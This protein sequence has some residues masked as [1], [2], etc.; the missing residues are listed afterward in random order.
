MICFYSDNRSKEMMRALVMSFRT[1][2]LAS[3]YL[4]PKI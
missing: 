4:Y 2:R 3:S 1:G